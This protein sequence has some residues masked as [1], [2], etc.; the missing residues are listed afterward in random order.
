MNVKFNSS[1]IKV[2]LNSGHIQGVLRST[3]GLQGYIPGLLFQIL[4]RG[5]G[6]QPPF[7]RELRVGSRVLMRYKECQIYIFLKVL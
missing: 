6:P 3:L 7:G 1:D 2:I 4:S 5:N